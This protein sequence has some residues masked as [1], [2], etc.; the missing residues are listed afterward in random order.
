[1]ETLSFRS[2]TALTDVEGETHELKQRVH[3]VEVLSE[4]RFAGHAGSAQ[5]TCFTSTQFTCFTV[6][7]QSEQCF[8]GHA[9]TRLDAY[10]RVCSR[11]L[12]YARVCSRMLAYAHVCS[13][14]LTYADVS[15]RMLTYAHVC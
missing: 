7:V 8:A 11:M 12:A 13:R 2:S 15:S 9:G 5:F 6:E 4:Q 3:T 10:A 14:K 1:V